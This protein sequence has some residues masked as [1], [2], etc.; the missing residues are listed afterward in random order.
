MN[1]ENRTAHKWKMILES[2]VYV[3]QMHMFLK[4]DYTIKECLTDW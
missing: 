2:T 3:T 4:P 1:P